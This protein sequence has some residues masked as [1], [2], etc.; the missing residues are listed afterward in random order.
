MSDSEPKS[1][2]LK[3]LYW[4]SE[5][6]QV[7]FWIEGEGFGE[8]VDDAVLERFLGLEPGRAGAYLD[9]L[10]EEELLV[11]TLSGR[12]RLSARGREEGKRTFAEEFAEVTRPAHGECGAECWCHQSPEEADACA[13]ER[14][15]TGGR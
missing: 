14:A 8:E 1:E 11:R 9:R 6:L 12:Y 3:A 15:G 13:A 5:I 10:V 7:L 4:R 2:R